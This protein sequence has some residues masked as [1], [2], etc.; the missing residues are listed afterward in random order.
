MYYRM[1]FLNILGLRMKTWADHSL[2][3]LSKQN[4]KGKLIIE[5]LKIK[6]NVKEIN[7]FTCF[8]KGGFGN[9]KIHLSNVVF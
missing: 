3:A 2:P 5:K 6:A 8:L 9:F 1:N 4:T 7:W